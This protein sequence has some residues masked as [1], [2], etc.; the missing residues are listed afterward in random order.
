MFTLIHFRRV[1]QSC[2]FKAIVPISPSRESVR[3]VETLLIPPPPTSLL[4]FVPQGLN[5]TPLSANFPNSSW[6][7][8]QNCFGSNVLF[9]VPNH[10]DSLWQIAYVKPLEP[11]LVS[12]SNP[13]TVSGA[14]KSGYF[15]HAITR[16]WTSSTSQQFSTERPRHP[17]P[18][19]C[20]ISTWNMMG[21]M[22]RSTNL[23]TFFAFRPLKSSC[24][25]TGHE[26]G[27]RTHIL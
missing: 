24:S 9:T 12:A 6:F 19:E 7:T 16:L 26:G 17:S 5:T 14:P 4:M 10:S 21:W 3:S 27:E 23:P 1:K 13:P 20:T 2:K 25:Y 15:T 11:A 22:T 18:W 8:G